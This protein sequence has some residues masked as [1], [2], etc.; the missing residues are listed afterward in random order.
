MNHENDSLIPKTAPATASTSWWIGLDRAQFA[1]QRTEE[2][3]RMSGSPFGRKIELLLRGGD[4]ATTMQRN[5]W[6]A[7][8]WGEL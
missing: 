8:P 2:Q 7:K 5:R 3:D 4:M 1:A 6:G